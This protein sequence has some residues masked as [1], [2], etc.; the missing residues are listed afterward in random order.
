[1]Q[2]TKD[3]VPVLWHDDAVVW[4][5]PDGSTISAAIADLTLPEFS[6]LLVWF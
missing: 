6:S 2:V 4:R 3:G 5:Q 1:M